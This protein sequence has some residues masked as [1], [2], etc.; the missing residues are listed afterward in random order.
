[1]PDSVR[2]TNSTWLSLKKKN[3]IIPA[4][5]LV[6]FTPKELG[7]NTDN[8]LNQTKYIKVNYSIRP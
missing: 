8:N 2:E 7:F 5:F 4:I 1:M 6:V 3:T